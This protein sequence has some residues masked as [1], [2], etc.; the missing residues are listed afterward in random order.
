M[1][2]K[3]VAAGGKFSVCH[4]GWWM[5]QWLCCGDLPCTV[6]GTCGIAKG[7]FD[8][9]W[10]CQVPS[11]LSIELLGR[12]TVN[13]PGTH[14]ILILSIVVP[15]SMKWMSHLLWIVC[16]PMVLSCCVAG[17]FSCWVK[18]TNCIL[19]AG[20]HSGL[21][22]PH[23]ELQGELWGHATS[24]QQPGGWFKDCAADT[25]TVTFFVPLRGLRNCCSNP[26][27]WTQNAE[28]KVRCHEAM[29]PDGTYWCDFRWQ[30]GCLAD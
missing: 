12:E 19:C 5:D 1:S 28:P 16:P 22:M 25:Q 6:H 21:P 2:E 20:R 17:P 23:G 24:D 13:K 14:A 26:A 11:N 30:G 15:P 10:I 18:I 29:R 7:Q 9:F 3:A 4:V 8:P 27:G